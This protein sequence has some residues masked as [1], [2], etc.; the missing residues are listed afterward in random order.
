M[1]DDHDVQAITGTHPEATVSSPGDAAPPPQAVRARNDAHF[2]AV[3]VQNLG[4]E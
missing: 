1:G 3:P 4:V 2:V